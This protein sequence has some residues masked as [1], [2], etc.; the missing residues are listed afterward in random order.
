MADISSVKKTARGLGSI[1]S[2][3]ALSGLVFAS[4][5][6]AS[7]SRALPHHWDTLPNLRISVLEQRFLFV[8]YFHDFRRPGAVIVR[9]Y[10]VTPPWIT[11]NVWLPP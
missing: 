3:S 7:L 6:V 2:M 5:L 1:S 10:I 8:R 11:L 9:T 4:G